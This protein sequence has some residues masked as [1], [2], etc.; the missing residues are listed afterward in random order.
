MI[1]QM[2]CLPIIWHNVCRK[3][4][5]NEKN[6]TETECV[7]LVPPLDTVMVA[8]TSTPILPILMEKGIPDGTKRSPLHHW[9]QPTAHQD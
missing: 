4:H 3:L 1:F 8:L 2:D 5:E 6:W 9:N 7:R